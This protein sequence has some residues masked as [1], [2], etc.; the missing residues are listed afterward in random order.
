M[1]RSWGLVA[2]FLVLVPPAVIAGTPGYVGVGKCKPCHLPE[3]TTW[4][5]SAHAG[6]LDT[7]KAG[8]TFAAECLKCHATNAS[9]STPGVQCEACHGPGSEYWPIPVM[10]DQKKAVQLGLLIQNQELCNGCHDGQDHH[11]KVVF[12][13]FKHDHR[14]KK[15]VVDLE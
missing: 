3:F 7:A 11:T 8:D 1:K 2:A 4:N 5:A 9:E 12:G 14:E 13:K 10:Y 6:A 15:G